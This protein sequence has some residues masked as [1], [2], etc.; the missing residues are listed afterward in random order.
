[1]T[2]R[3]RFRPFTGDSE[4]RVEMSR[5]PLALVLVQARWPE[6]GHL[7]LDFKQ[8]ALTFGENL[9][10]FPLY[11]EIVDQGF[12]LTTEGVQPVRGETT[13]QWRS[14]DDVW[15]VQLNKT[16]VSLY[17]TPHVDYRYTELAERL[18]Q[19]IGLLHSVLKIQVTDR[20]GVRY[21]NRL[22][23][24]DFMSELPSIF[25]HRVLGMAGLEGNHGVQ[26]VNTL[27]QAIYRIEDVTLHVRSGYLGPGETMDP[28]IVPVPTQS[29]ILDLDASQEARLIYS[30]GQIQA[31]AGRL[32]DTAYDFFKLVLNDDGERQL[33]GHS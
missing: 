4:R 17:C 15:V 20:I 2:E 8:L 18:D 24:P 19:I 3:V 28:S 27:S 10:G 30:P 23:E 29:W 11:Q 33:D 31:V 26:L 7:A 21:V 5:A 16:F 13:Y 25:D 32:A 14:L 12:Q 1:M 9:D 6:H 22:S